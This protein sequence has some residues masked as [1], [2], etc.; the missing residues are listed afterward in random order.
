MGSLADNRGQPAKEVLAKRPAD[1]VPI[2]VDW[3]DFLINERMPGVAIAVNYVVRPR[4]ATA[5][6]LEYKCT[7]AGVTSFVPYERILWPKVAAQTITDGS[8][9][10]TAQ[11]V[12]ASSLRATISGNVWT[13]DSGV[14]KSNESN[15]DFVYTAFADGGSNGQIYSLRHVV[16]LS[17]SEVKEALILLPV[18][19]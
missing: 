10:W 3:H 1:K 9:V 2:D 4:R 8:V 15:A 17:S 5:T 16:T 13:F 6:G 19:D 11:A 18:S 7:T 12:S 14:N